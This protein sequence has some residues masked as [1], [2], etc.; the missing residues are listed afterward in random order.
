MYEVSHPSA[1]VLLANAR[2]RLSGLQRPVP[3]MAWAA[4]PGQF[5]LC[6]V[7]PKKVPQ[8]AHSRATSAVD[9]EL[10]V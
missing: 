9:N 10:L 1:L 4:V 7:T 3:C 2:L 8:V 6:D 5:C